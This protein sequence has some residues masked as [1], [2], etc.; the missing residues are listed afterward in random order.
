MSRETVNAERTDEIAPGPVVAVSPHLDDAVMSC[1][2]LL[3]DRPGSSVI[4]VFAGDAPVADELTDWDAECGFARGEE[5]VAIRRGEDASALRHVVAR[6]RWLR[7]ADAQYA[8]TPPLAVL[9]QA[10]AES[11][12][13]NGAAPVV[14]PLGLFHSDHIATSNAALRVAAADERRPWYIYV[15]AVYRR[16]E[17]AATE[18]LDEIRRGGARLADVTF[19]ASARAR[20]AKE[21]AIAEYRS[22]RRGLG[23]RMNDSFAPERYYRIER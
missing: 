5:V 2:A 17:G 13:D 9:A 16:I 6:P 10:I 18:R 12:A 23:T 4:T 7:F 3:A 1:G 8:P 21:A 19:S 14:A 22:Q 20:R 15:D 11:V